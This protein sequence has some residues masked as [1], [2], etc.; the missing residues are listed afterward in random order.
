MDLEEADTD[1]AGMPVLKRV[2]SKIATLERRADHLEGQLSEWRG[3]PHGRDFAR[4]ELSAVKAGVAA[5]RYHRSEIEGLD[6]PIL[7]LQELVEAVKEE[8][9]WAKSP[10]VL[11]ASAILEEWG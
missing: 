9:A 4:A 3:S 11:R 1:P 8:A 5:L 2:S 7:A 6:Q 10:E